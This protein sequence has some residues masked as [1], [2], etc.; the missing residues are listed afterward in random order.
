MN[1]IF[2]VLKRELETESF[3]VDAYDF[4]QKAL[5]SSKPNVHVEMAN[6]QRTNSRPCES[7]MLM[8]YTKYK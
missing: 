4:P 7:L 5:Y 1:Q 2:E 8:G 3:Q 6:A